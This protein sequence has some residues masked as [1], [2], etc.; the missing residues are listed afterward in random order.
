MG[1]HGTMSDHGHYTDVHIDVD[2]ALAEE[3]PNGIGR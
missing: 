1:G 3:F 2:S